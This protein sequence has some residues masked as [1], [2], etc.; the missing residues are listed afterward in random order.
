ML[1]GISMTVTGKMIKRKVLASILM[2]TEIIMKVNS[3]KIR[4]KVKANM[5]IRMEASMSV[6]I[7]ITIKKV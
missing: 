7:K 5:F 3:D 1:T 2:P 4:Q 6:N